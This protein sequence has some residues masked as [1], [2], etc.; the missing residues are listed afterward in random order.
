MK[1]VIDAREYSSST[2]RYVRKLIE[3]LEQLPSEHSFEVLL[4]PEDFEAYQPSN[5]RFT[6]WV[7]DFEKFTF[8]EQLGFNR[9]LISLGADLVHFSMSQQPTGYKKLKITTVHDLTALRF[10]DPQKNKLLFGMKQ[11][12]YARV[13]KAAVRDSR[14]VLTATEFVR[15]DVLQFTGVD[16]HKVAVTPEAAD[17]IKEPTEPIKTLVGKQ[18]IMYLGRPQPHKNLKRLIDA[19]AL[20]QKTNPDLFLA[21]AGKTDVLYE[22]HKAYAVKKGIKNVVQTGFVSEGQ[23]KWLYQNCR[24]YIFPSL[25]EG[26]G[27]PGLEAM[28]HGA[29]VVSSNA[30][31]LPEVYGEAAHY[32]DPLNVA[33]MAA[34]INEVIDSEKLRAKLIKKGY[35]QASKYSWRRMAEQTLAAYDKALK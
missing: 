28:I 4:S 35:A 3:N 18:F 21:L 33:D 8:A 20:L 6:K 13:I 1:I 25:S 26:F 9:F 32:F 24:A 14:V 12:A 10:K 16:P 17:E 30:T 5:Q 27:L 23:L 29:P 2:G 22:Q 19:F 11:A 31:C 34:K 15:N 7:A